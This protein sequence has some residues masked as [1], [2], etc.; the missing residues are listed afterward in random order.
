L[1][2]IKRAQH[3]YYK[4][5][6]AAELDLEQGGGVFSLTHAWGERYRKV[7]SGISF[8]YEERIFPGEARI[9]DPEAAS[10]P[11]IQENLNP[12]DRRVYNL[13]FHLERDRQRF[14]KF[15]YLDYFGRTEDLPT[16]LQHGFGLL[17]SRNDLGPD[18]LSGAISARWARNFDRSKYLVTFTSLRIRREQGDWNNLIADFE[19]HYYVQTGPFRYGP[20]RGPRQT[21]A[22]NLSSTLTR[23][24]ESP[25]QL[26]LGED[27]GLRGYSFRSLTGFNRILLNFEDR[28]FT[29]WENRLGGIGFVSFVDAGYVWGKKTHDDQFG[30]SVGIGARFG[31]K[32][33]GRTRVFRVDLAFPLANAQG[34]G[35][36]LSV[37]SGQIFNVL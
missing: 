11:E 29:Y 26:S 6:D 9:L 21:L 15:T 34:R 14:V 3:L 12:D 16:G 28:I 13:G 25:F 20:V 22:W 35:I 37:S 32:K 24:V 4:G 17:Y 36:S 30:A 31:F 10:Q 18:F 1:D 19:A 8:G 5:I 27:E 33:Y 23:D 2:R 7:R